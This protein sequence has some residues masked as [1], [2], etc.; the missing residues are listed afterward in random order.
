[1]GFAYLEKDDCENALNRFEYALKNSRTD[2]YKVYSLLLI[3]RT[4]FST[5][6]IDNAIEKC[7]EALSILPND[8]EANYSLLTYE[9]FKLPQH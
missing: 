4:Y 9:S 6:K 3:S 8:N 5:G 7:K 1:M 2:K